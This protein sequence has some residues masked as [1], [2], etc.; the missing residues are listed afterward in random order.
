MFQ[1][2]CHLFLSNVVDVSNTTNK[3]CE[4]RRFSL[5]CE[6][7]T[8]L[9]S[10]LIYKIKTFFGSSIKPDHVIKTYWKDEHDDLVC[11]STD[12]ETE[13]A[14]Y[15]S[16][17]PENDDDLSNCFIIFVTAFKPSD[18]VDFDFTIKCYLFPKDVEISTNN[19]STVIETRTFQ[20]KSNRQNL[21]NQLIKSIRSAEFSRIN[22]EA[23]DGQTFKTYWQDK[24]NDL[25]RF[26]TDQETEYAFK[27]HKNILL[28]TPSS[29]PPVFKLFIS[30]I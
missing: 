18:I 15:M 25:I 29:I 11:F 16:L 30:K 23:N 19:I 7:E 6:R 13:N 17:P 26:S 3:A 8:H 27:F 28:E 20:I 12:E 21:Y 1:V 22:K 9:Y 14:F 24:D 4:T 10:T 2:K 5:D